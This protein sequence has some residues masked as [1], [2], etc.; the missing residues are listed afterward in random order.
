MEPT[1]EGAIELARSATGP[2][3]PYLEAF[4]TSLVDQQYTAIS[5]RVKSW[6]AVAFDAWLAKHD[7][8]LVGV[9]DTHI[10]Q[11]H[12][13]SYQPRSDCKAEPRIHETS[14]LRHLLRYLREQ[15]LCTPPPTATT[16]ADDLVA[17]FERFLLHDKG[18]ATTTVDYYRSRTR[19]FLIHRFGTGEVDLGNLSAAN[20]IDFIRNQSRQLRPKSLK[21]VITALRAFLRYAQYR[22]ETSAALVNAVPAVAAWSTTP[23]LPRA[24]SPEH[25]RSV[26]DSCDTSTSMGLRDRAVLLL[27]S[28][29][30]LRGGEVLALLLEDIDWDTSRLSIR[31]KNGRV[32][33]MP[34][35]ADVGEAI[36]MYLQRGRPQSDDRHVFLRTRA[37]IKGFRHGSD[38]IG[39]LVCNALRRAGINAPHK[40][41]HQFRYALAVRMLKRGASLPEIGEVLR[42]RSPMATSIYAKVDIDVLRGLALPWPGGAS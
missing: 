12:R 27:L 39:S 22:G 40:G 18:L 14:A 20:V 21:S 33:L 30:G 15:G 41:S 24:I 19:D 42:H 5:L 4:V 11:F 32:C 37:P 23:P 13:R 36:A 38:S 9:S 8:A 16:S 6:H 17:S 7:I 3:S 29:L 26:I 1:C 2:L 35:P 25:A 10:D 28:R 31:G 34:M